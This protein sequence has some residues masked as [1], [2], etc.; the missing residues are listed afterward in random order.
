MSSSAKE[1][2]ANNIDVSSDTAVEQEDEY[3]V[4]K[5]LDKRVIKN[6]VEY[7]LKWNGYDD[8]DNTWEPLENLNCKDLIIDF[9]K[10]LKQQNDRKKKE[11][12][13]RGRKRTSSEA[14]LSQ[15]SK[16]HRNSSIYN[17]KIRVEKADESSEAGPS[18]PKKSK[19]L[20]TENNENSVTEGSKEIENNSTT[21]SIKKQVK[22]I[23]GATN[24]NGS[25]EFLVKWEGL[26]KTEFVSAEEL[27][28]KC[29]QILIKYYEGKLKWRDEPGN[30]N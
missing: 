4:E 13:E 10:N 30:N 28:L 19:T 14:G 8:T 16:K 29:P 15:D 6:K 3:I 21:T 23:I 2:V 12:L 5:I 24:F 17:S 26:R 11:K 22:E 1:I 27:K 18:I 20:L 7:F 9:E 25:L